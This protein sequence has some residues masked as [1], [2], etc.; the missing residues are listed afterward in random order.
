MRYTV[1]QQ[2]GETLPQRHNIVLTHR[3]E[4]L[5][6]AP[7]PVTSQSTALQQDAEASTTT[8][9]VIGCGSVYDQFLAIRWASSD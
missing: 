8:A 9:Y 7:V 3:P 6:E 1:C 5:P 4:S 2:F